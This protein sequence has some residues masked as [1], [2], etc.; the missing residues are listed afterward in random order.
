MARPLH[1]YRLAREFDASVWVHA[2]AEVTGVALGLLLRK[3][4]NLAA[5]GW[6]DSPVPDDARPT[7]AQTLVALGY[8]YSC[9]DEVGQGQSSYD[10]KHRAERWGK[11]YIDQRHNTY[12]SN[13]AAIA[14][15]LLC[16]WPARRRGLNSIVASP[17]VASR[18][19][20]A[21]SRSAKVRALQHIA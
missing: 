5:S 15:L 14:A 4:P 7:H 9:V 12:V 11:K 6:L 1:P 16:R 18:S 10:I 8:L 17:I 20:A 3:H 19:F 21:E 2:S 13:G